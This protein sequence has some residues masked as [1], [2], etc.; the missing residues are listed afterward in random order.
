[1]LDAINVAGGF[2]STADPRRVRITHINANGTTTVLTVNAETTNE[3]EIPATPQVVPN[4]II[5]VPQ[6]LLSG[7]ESIVVTGSVDSPGPFLPTAQNHLQTLIE[8]IDAAG[9]FSP[10]A[11]LTRVRIVRHVIAAGTTATSSTTV[12]VDA[13]LHGTEDDPLLSA[14]DSIFV[15]ERQSLAGPR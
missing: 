15:P 8:A 11:D 4:D 7:R 3:G 12:N 5:F 14:G 9:G 6:N 13:V 1:M 2:D 10:S